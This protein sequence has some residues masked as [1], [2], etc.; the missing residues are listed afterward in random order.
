MSDQKLTSWACSAA[1]SGKRA[2]ENRKG[3]RGLHATSVI[4]FGSATKQPGR[5][6]RYCAMATMSAGEVIAT[7]M[8]P[9]VLNPGYGLQRVET[10]ELGA[11]R[12]RINPYSNSSFPPPGTK[13]R[14]SGLRRLTTSEASFPRFQPTA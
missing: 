11:R 5:D 8:R 12:A 6:C 10:F 7:S 13:A 2:K 4:V 9:R 14:G 1:S 3:G